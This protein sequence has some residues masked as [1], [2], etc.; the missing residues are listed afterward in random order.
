[1]ARPKLAMLLLFAAILAL[2]PALHQHSLI[3]DGSS[4][5]SP[6]TICVACAIN[7]GGMIAASAALAAPAWI[8]L[9]FLLLAIETPAFRPALVLPAR[10]PPVR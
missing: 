7:A 8:L 2:E 3:P 4:L 9:A 10:A 5:A 6:Q 1:M